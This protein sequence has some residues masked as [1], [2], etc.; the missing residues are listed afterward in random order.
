VAEN[1]WYQ[2]PEKE[3]A[4]IDSV[5]YNITINP[6][7]LQALKKDDMLNQRKK[8]SDLALPFSASD[9]LEPQGWLKKRWA[10][11]SWR[12]NFGDVAYGINHGLNSDS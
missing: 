1:W 10:I 4:D 9:A 7:G 6:A 12:Y 8:H 3:I 11:S 2:K 5:G